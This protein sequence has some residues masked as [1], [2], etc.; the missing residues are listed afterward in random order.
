MEKNI[1]NLTEEELRQIIREEVRAVLNE[2]TS[3]SGGSGAEG[4]LDTDQAA[5][6]IKLKKTTLYNLINQNKIPFHKS[7]KRVLFKRTELIA[8]VN[9][10]RG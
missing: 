3:E 8:W 1:S 4:F 7:G 9:E 6:L 5:D 2:R 10:I